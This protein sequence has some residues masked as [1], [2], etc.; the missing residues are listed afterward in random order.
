MVNDVE[1]GI[2]IF[3]TNTNKTHICNDIQELIVGNFRSCPTYFL[4]L[5]AIH[6]CKN[7]N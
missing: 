2:I 7:G 3:Y 5:C 1:S 6:G 4:Q